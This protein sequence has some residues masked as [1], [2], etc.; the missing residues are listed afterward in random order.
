[1]SF[2]PSLTLVFPLMTCVLF[3]VHLAVVVDVKFNKVT[4]IDVS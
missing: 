3:L 1:M 2:D 4:T